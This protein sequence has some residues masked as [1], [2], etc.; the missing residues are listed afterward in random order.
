MVARIRGSSPNISLMASSVLTPSARIRLVMG[1]FRFL[2]IRTQNTSE[3][4]VSYSSQAP[5]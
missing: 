4:S 2:S 3:L 5:R 1:S